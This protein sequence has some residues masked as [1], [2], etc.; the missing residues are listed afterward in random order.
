M[1]S[2]SILSPERRIEL[3][4]YDVDAWNILL[5]E[6]QA[7]PIDQARPF[8][9]KL[10]GQFPNAGRYWK[11]YIE[12]ELRAKN[13]ENVEALF[14]RCLIS[15]LHI[16][17]WKCYVFY[18]RETKGHLSSFREKMAQAY[19]FALEKVGLDMLSHSIYSDYI[20]FLK[21]VPAVGQYAENQ[22]ISAIRKVYQRGIATPMLNI[23]QLWNEYTSY[24][25][26]I[27][28]TLAEKLIADKNKDFQNAKKVTRQLENLMRGINRQA[29]SVPPR[30]SAAEMKQVELWRKYILWEKSNP[31]NTEEYSHFAKRVIYAYDQAL[32]SL[33]YYPDIWYEA[34]LFQQE[35][36]QKLAEKG[37]VK[38]SN[39]MVAETTNLYE[40]AIGGLMKDSPLMYFAFADFEEE[41]RKFENV[42]KIYDRLLAREF[43][44]PTLA[45]VMLMKFV[46]RTEGVKATRVVFKRARED[47]RS[48][49]HVYVAHALMEY[50]CN[51][52][53]EVA[54]RIFD[55]GLKQYGSDPDYALAY[56]DFLSH[57]NEDNNTRVVFERILGSSQ[58][59]PEKSID[60]WDRYLEFESQVG[61]LTSILK[62]DQRRREALKPYYG[63][64]QALLLI[65]RYKFGNLV[66]CTQEQLKF[67]GYNKS[68]RPIAGSA[69]PSGP[70][71]SIPQGRTPM[72]ANGP[73]AVMGG[74]NGLSLEMSGYPRPDTNQ[75]LP[76]KPKLRPA[77]SYHPVPGGLFPP[78]S[79]VSQLMKLIPPPWSFQGPFVD[80]DLLL[81]SFAKFNRDPPKVKSEP[82]DPNG[83]FGMYKVADIKKE[84]H[85]LL[86][87]TNDPMVVLASQEYQQQFLS[88]KRAGGGE[89][90][91]DD[92]SRNV[93]AGDIY[94]RRMNM[95]TGE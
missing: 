51:K 36:A 15:V 49:H 44:D 63:D 39:A 19:D 7:R 1:A 43:V 88:R 74:Q 33:G 61:D 68:I 54:M 91:S 79:Q 66:P 62:V 50:Y 56:T 4:P 76:F 78:P 77:F 45:Y 93:G 67:M 16:D 47:Q 85:Q 29:I 46:R 23:E 2:T 52:D 6:H 71:P 48:Q 73:S 94:K 18:V 26:G 20:S 28:P 95:K 55:F 40:R 24:E 72:I 42:K 9:E 31:T 64:K 84:F 80:V 30:G 59:P 32:L 22:R 70:T 83:N 82:I 37:D 12:H 21:T 65:D 81:D 27:N 11:S 57:L 92:E 14:S 5:R 3:N 38:M 34:A 53:S 58:L 8:Y 35:A 90:D 69:A 87:T 86:T 41:R 60:L 75:M 10:I 25:K 89:S 13:F 17:L